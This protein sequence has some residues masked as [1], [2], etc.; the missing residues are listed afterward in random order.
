M[1]TKKAFT[2]I[3]L[4]VVIA[5]IGIVAALVVNMVGGAQSA[6][7]NALVNAEKTKL[8]LM[9]ENYQAKLNYYPPDNGN[10]V[11]YKMANYALNYDGWAATNPLLYELTGAIVTNNNASIQ[12]YDGAPAVPVATF[13]QIFNRTSVNNSDTTDPQNFF[14]PPPTAKEIASYAPLTTYSNISGLLVPVPVTNKSSINFWHY[15]SSSTNR[16]NLSGYDLW[17][18]Y[19]SGSKSGTDVIVT[20]GN[21]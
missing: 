13:A 7:R 15:D 16:H 20:S 10:L 11:N 8:Q 18:E 21:W 4:L 3:E 19:I 17:A 12:L 2:L 14:R 1:N 5:I 9:I 6:K